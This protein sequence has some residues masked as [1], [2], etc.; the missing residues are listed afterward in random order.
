MNWLLRNKECGIDTKD[1]DKTVEYRICVFV[2]EMLR[3]EQIYLPEISVDDVTCG[4]T[5]CHSKLVESLN[6]ERMTDN[7]L[8]GVVRFCRRFSREVSAAYSRKH[9]LLMHCSRNV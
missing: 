4:F 2:W 7:D 5:Q 9:Q 6:V 8:K 3:A 1:E